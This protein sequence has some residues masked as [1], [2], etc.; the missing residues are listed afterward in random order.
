[1]LCSHSKWNTN[2][3]RRRKNL[4]LSNWDSCHSSLALLIWNPRPPNSQWSY[5]YSIIVYGLES[6]K[7]DRFTGEICRLG[8]INHITISPFLTLLAPAKTYLP[9]KAINPSKRIGKKSFKQELI[10][11]INHR[12]SDGS[13]KKVHWRISP[14]W[15]KKKPKHYKSLFSQ[16]YKKLSMN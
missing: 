6:M 9:Q 10:V 5:W 11:H 2:H 12:F 8:S 1:M 15:N 16:E 3:R 13:K 7:F 14:V 4:F